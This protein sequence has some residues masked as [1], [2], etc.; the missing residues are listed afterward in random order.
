[1]RKL[2]KNEFNLL[3]SDLKPMEEFFRING[4]E[5]ESYIKKY[6]RN[7]SISAMTQQE[8]GGANGIIKKK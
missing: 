6:N 8:L 4:L 2:N 3:N 5:S 7:L 1:M